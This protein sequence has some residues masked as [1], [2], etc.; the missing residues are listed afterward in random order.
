MRG[1][2]SIY[3]NAWKPADR[4]TVAIK[5]PTCGLTAQSPSFV[6]LGAGTY[7]SVGDDFPPSTNVALAISNVPSRPHAGSATTARKFKFH[8]VF[9]N[10]NTRVNRGA[11]I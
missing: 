11:C 7:L 3:Y 5:V 9:S 8:I 10:L 6:A 1:V 4:A 2:R